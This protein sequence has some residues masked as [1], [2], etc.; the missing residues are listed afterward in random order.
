ME[1]ALSAN[2]LQGIVDEGSSTLR[3]VDS[4]TRCDSLSESNHSIPTQE[5]KVTVALQEVAVSSA[6]GQY[7]ETSSFIPQETMV[8][9]R[10]TT[11]TSTR[12]RSVSMSLADAIGDNDAEVSEDCHLK[13]CAPEP[14]LEADEDTETTREISTTIVEIQIG[15]Q[16]FELCK[17]LGT[18]AFGKVVLVQNRLNRRYYAMKVI[19]KH[20]IK[21]KNNLQYMKSERD[22]LT[23]V[24]HP[25][26]VSLQFAF[27]SETKLFLV[28]DFLSG[29][30]LFLH[31]RRRGLIMEKEVQFY[32]GEMILAMEFL[33]QR[34]II[35]RDL[36][37]ENVL[38]RS[39]AHICITDFGLAKE[40]GNDMN[41]RTLCGTSE[42]MAPEMLTRSGYGKA[43]DWWAL[44]ALAYEML[45]GKPPFTSKSNNQK[46]L[47]KKIIFEKLST[48]SYLTGV[49]VSLLRGML[50]KDPTKRLG[51][52]K[53]TM[54]NLGG[55]TMLKQHEFFSGVDWMALGNLQLVP[56]IN[57][58]DNS[59]VDS[60]A[61]KDTAA[62]NTNN[63][64]K[65]LETKFFSEE[66]TTQVLSPSLLEDTYSTHTP[67]PMN[68]SRVVSGRNSPSQLQL[69]DDPFR[70]FE[71]TDTT[72]QCTAHQLEEY[73]QMMVSKQ[74]KL[75]KKKSLRLK[76]EQ[77]QAEEEAERKLRLEHE[78]QLRIVRMEQERQRKEQEA[79]AKQEREELARQQKL[80]SQKEKERLAHN[81]RVQQYQDE[82]TALQK[83]VK[84]A[85]KKL[86]EIQDLR[87]KLASQQ[88]EVN[89]DQKQKLA[90]E[91][92]VDAELQGLLVAEQK[93]IAACPGE[94]IPAAE[95]ENT[96]VE[97]ASAVT[98]AAETTTTVDSS[99]SV[100]KAS[101]K[102]ANAWSTLPS[103]SSSAAAVTNSSQQS[104]SRS[105]SK[106]GPSTATSSGQAAPAS[107]ATA[108]TAASAKKSSVVVVDE[109]AT[110]GTSGK[111]KGKPR[112]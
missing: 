68:R 31:L 16:H 91:K 39:D 53:S 46:E 84:N 25:F 74:Q 9:F 89:K 71:Y 88:A 78:E 98:A 22:I 49:A 50:E 54:F 17:L 105:D 13:S 108:D 90:K 27:Q 36:K 94:I 107:S 80:K 92:E 42:Y 100:T 64:D 86:R 10:T 57:L 21:K 35:H 99:S 77:K 43:V 5:T 26:L 81:T 23:K 34:G 101:G 61:K 103:S 19:S 82:L 41:V 40:I 73:Q 52:A 8:A 47:D 4:M 14:A 51:C 79:I 110:V 97:A 30:E 87:E 33:H 56:P 55:I 3:K 59:S 85:R 65:D 1:P 60:S 28:M 58:H 75:L 66:F 7:N 112:G 20:L 15:P 76:K 95:E 12:A 37:P 67:S 111:K 2:V 48:P 11:V 70:N 24:Q 45:V 104:A 62:V 109:W 18:G 29:G 83:R 38:L 72:F 44:G 93:M 102:P 63:I 32:L 6:G 106:T 69:E 96:V